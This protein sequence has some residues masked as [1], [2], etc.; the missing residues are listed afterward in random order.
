MDKLVNNGIFEA[1]GLLIFENEYDA[2]NEILLLVF[3]S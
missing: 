1:Y 2:K 3:V